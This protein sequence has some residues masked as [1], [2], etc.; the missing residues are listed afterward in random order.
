[1]DK[2]DKSNA[3][4]IIDGSGLFGP[5]GAY[6]GLS[7]LR[8]DDRGVW[9]DKDGCADVSFWLP[10][11]L[12]KPYWELVDHPD[13]PNDPNQEPGLPFPFDE[14]QLAAWMMGGLGGQIAGHYG[15]WDAG[16]DQ[17]MLA[18][19]DARKARRGV[20]RAFELVRAAMLVVGSPPVE[21][22]S[23][24][25]LAEDEYARALGE[26]KAREGDIDRAR[27][28]LIG[29]RE[30]ADALKVKSEA[31]M[32]FWRRA[33]VRQL[34]DAR[35]ATCARQAQINTI[36]SAQATPEYQRDAAHAETVLK[37]LDNANA[38][39]AMMTDALGNAPKTGDVGKIR[40]A[41]AAVDEAQQDVE[42]V[43]ATIERLRGDDP[44]MGE[45]AFVDGFDS[46]T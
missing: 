3:Q 15:D 29:L 35:R 30:Q 17:E 6:S 5:D 36:L 31:A 25:H 45:A 10:E 26:A 33:M 9:P 20:T 40:E 1:M 8:V 11:Y 27:A 7:F 21:V 43:Q 19:P 44:L 2:Y 22:Q 38:T 39:L 13:E 34:H 41:Q 32:A 4:M 46:E 28:L 12:W 14:Y 18:H 24:W 37:R 42:R 16:P 23:Q